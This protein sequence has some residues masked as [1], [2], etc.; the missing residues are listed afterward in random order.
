MGVKT[1][2]KRDLVDMVAVKTPGTNKTEVLAVVQTF[3]DV[4]TTSL[5]NGE[6]IELRDFG[7]FTPRDRAARKAR[8]PKTGAVV[9]VPA[10]RTVA[11]KLGKEFKT[12]LN[13]KAAVKA[14][15]AAK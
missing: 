13:T 11:F 4:I 2:T 3:L 14:P 12:R 10:S 5:G 9:D 1:V 7:V 15:S 6:R 8:N